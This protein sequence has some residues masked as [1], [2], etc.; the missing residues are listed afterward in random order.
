M[1]LVASTSSLHDARFASRRHRCYPDLRSYKGTMWGLNISSK[2]VLVPIRASVLALRSAPPWDEGGPR[3]AKT[4]V[5]WNQ[6]LKE[7]G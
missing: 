3:K 4:H 5:F 7:V 6:R 2:A 1:Y